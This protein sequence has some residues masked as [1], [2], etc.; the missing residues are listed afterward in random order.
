MSP[1]FEHRIRTQTET[2]LVDVQSR[3]I[4]DEID[5]IAPVEGSHGRVHL[6]DFH[7]DGEWASPA[8]F[9]FPFDE[10]APFDQ[11]LAL[12]KDMIA[13]NWQSS[14]IPPPYQDLQ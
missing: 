4:I 2:L 10:S 3:I 9:T 6:V 8:G 7:I 11:S 1:T 14:A 5:V 12:L 13:R